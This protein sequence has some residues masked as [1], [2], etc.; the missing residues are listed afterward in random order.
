MKIIYNETKSHEGNDCLIYRGAIVAYVEEEDAYVLTKNGNDVCFGIA[1]KNKLNNT[2]FLNN[3][4]KAY[5]PASAVPTANGIS[6]YGL[7]FDDEEG[8]TAVE[9]VE[10]VTEDVVIFDLSGRRVNEITAPGIYI[11]GGKKVLVK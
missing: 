8:T 11:I 3:A 4:N 7:R 5:L 1:I 2:A 9:N 10:V 6:F